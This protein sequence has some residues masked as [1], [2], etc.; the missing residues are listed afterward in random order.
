M[1]RGILCLGLVL[2]GTLQAP[3]R[4]FLISPIPVPLLVSIPLQPDFQEDQFQGKWYVIGIAGNSINATRRA[5]FKM[6]TTTYE[7]KDDHSYN[8]TSTMIRNESCDHWIRT[9]VPSLLP[10]QFTL[11][12][13]KSHVGVQNYT[14]RV[15]MTNYNQVA[16]VFFKKVHDN[17]E[18]FKITLYGRT[19]QL[20][21]NL[22]KYFTRFAKSL[23]LTDNHIIFPVP[24][25]KCIDDE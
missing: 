15:M 12:D 19:K 25:D 21:T 2:L 18:F 22:K 4:D 16:M 7:L 23:G 8:V 5:R 13:I 1:A 20:S 11:G 14:V 3:A 17:H 10:G 6:Y 9:F 24:I